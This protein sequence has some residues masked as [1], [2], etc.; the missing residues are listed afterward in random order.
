MINSRKYGR[1]GAIRIATRIILTVLG[2]GL[3]V[4]TMAC[5][6]LLRAD[7]EQCNQ[8]ADCAALEGAPAGAQCVQSRCVSETVVNVAD[9]LA[10]AP[11]S[12]SVDATVKYSFAPVFGPGREPA[13]PKPFVVKACEQLDISCARPTFGPLEVAAAQPRD[14]VVPNGFNGYFEMQNPDTLSALLFSGQLLTT[15]TVGWALTMPS[16]TLVTELGQATGVDVQAELGLIIAVARACDGTPLE[17]VTASS[18]KGGLGYY[19]VNFLPDTALTKTGPQ[20][21]AGF[22][23]VPPGVTIVTGVHESGKKFGPVS[24]VTRPNYVSFVEL[25]P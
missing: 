6:V 5:S 11:H 17:G 7:D 12:K 8:D 2:V 24:V 4:S 15:D 22:A 19:L 21:V 14:F 16:R 9:P 3:G 25:W 18:S 1:A 10:C 20:G 23:N 13:Q